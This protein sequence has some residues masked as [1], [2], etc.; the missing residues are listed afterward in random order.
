MKLWFAWLIELTKKIILL[1]I[2]TSPQVW[3][4]GIDSFFKVPILH[5][6]CFI[7]FIALSISILSWYFYRWFYSSCRS[8][9]FFVSLPFMYSNGVCFWTANVLN[10]INNTIL[11]IYITL[12][13]KQILLEIIKPFRSRKLCTIQ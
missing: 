8:F 1:L 12:I 13:R 7:T 5:L 6:I 2:D 11:Y 4:T 10:I 3:N 9:M